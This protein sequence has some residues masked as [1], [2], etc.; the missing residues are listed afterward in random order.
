MAL[1]DPGKGGEMKD[2]GRTSTFLHLLTSPLHGALLP[3]GIFGGVSNSGY[4]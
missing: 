1:E 4:S 2:V 3:V